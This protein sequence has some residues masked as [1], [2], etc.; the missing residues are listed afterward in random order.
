MGESIHEKFTYYFSEFND[1]LFRYIAYELKMEKEEALDLLEDVW[2]TFW[3]KF[4]QIQDFK[5]MQIR[6]W[7]RKTAY[8]KVRNY[9]R[10]KQYCSEILYPEEKLEKLCPMAFSGESPEEA[11]L[12]ECIRLLRPIEQEVINIRREGKSYQDISRIMNRSIQSLECI[13][14]RAVKK[15]KLLVGRKLTSFW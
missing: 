15:L 13:H 12:E 11:V 4:E 14:S 6:K 8:Y 3:E 2:V 7:L 9:K 5:D 10:R 1:E